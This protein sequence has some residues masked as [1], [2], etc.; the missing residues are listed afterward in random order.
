MKFPAKQ[1]ERELVYIGLRNSCEISRGDRSARY[2]ARRAWYLRGT[3]GPNMCRYNKLAGAIR[4]YVGFVFAAEMTRYGIKPPRQYSSDRTVIAQAMVASNVF[5]EAWHDADCAAAINTGLEWASVYDTI[6]VKVMKTAKGP[7]LYLIHPGN[8][9]VLR[10]GVPYLDRQE[11]FVEWYR[12][13][14]SELERSLAYHPDGKDLFRR[15]ASQATTGAPLAPAQALT[16]AQG[17][18]QFSSISPTMVGTAG[19]GFPIGPEPMED[20]PTVDCAELWVWDDELGDHDETHDPPRRKGNYR[21]VDMHVGTDLVM[22]DRE[23]PQDWKESHPYVFLTPETDLGYIW[24][25]SKVEPL[26]PLQQWREDLMNKI[27]QR[28]E[29][30]LKP[31]RTFTGWGGLNEDRVALLNRPN[32]FLNNPN[33]SGKVETFSPEMPPDAFAE[34]KE[35]DRMFSERLGLKGLLEGQADPSVRNTGQAGV[36]ASLASAGIRTQSLI[37]EDQIEEIA[38]KFFRILQITDQ[39]EYVYQEAEGEQPAERFLLAHLPGDTVV[40]VAAHTSSPLYAERLEAKAAALHKEGLLDAE[41]YLNML[42]I[43]LHELLGP[44]AKRM[45]EQKA[46]KL[47]AVERTKLETDR[48]KAIRPRAR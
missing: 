7:D 18:L 13:G 45:Q 21:V 6:V 15:I 4:D 31:P 25:R 36:M 34:I 40:K 42:D 41:D 10:E 17:R 32:G 23:A 33:L 2:A 47:E 44:K 24:G 16:S 46:A 43:P 8:F 26:M 9:G 11:A 48:L 38:T 5:G 28:I 35:I 20:E 29:L 19:I 3:E 30:Q 39:G 37:I 22:W 1:E 14:V 27:G 12:M